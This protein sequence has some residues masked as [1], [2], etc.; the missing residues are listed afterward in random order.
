MLMDFNL[1]L[2]QEQKL[3]MTQQMQLSIKLLQM[4]TYDLREYIE[5][6]FSENPVLEAQYEDTKEVS[7]E[8]D[9]LEYKELVKYLESDNYGSQSYGEYDEEGISPFT[10]I[11]KPESLTDYLEGQILEL[12]IDE[13][14]RSVCSYMVECLDQKGYLDI[15]KEE[16]MNELDCSEETFNRALIVIQ[17]L[18]P[19][20]IGARDLKECLEIQLERKGENYPIVKEIIDNHLDDLADN[21][22]QV[23]AKDLDITPKKAQD[24][25]DLIKTLEPK[26]SRGFYTG[27][28]VGFII[29]D[30]EI[31]KIDGEFFI[32]MKDGVLPMLSVNPLYKDILKDSTNDKE[33]TEYVKEK[34]DKAMF[35]IK[36]IE[37]R[38]STLHKVLQKILEKQKDYFEKGEKYLKPMTLKEIAEKLE[39][40][41]S[42]ISRAIRDKYILTSMGTIKIKDLFVN[43]ISNKEKS[44]GEE[45]V[46]VINIKKVLEEVIK[47][48]DKRKPLS[49]QAI[50]EILKEKGMAISRRT[51][52]KYREE[53]GIKSSS[54]RKR[55]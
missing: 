50:S 6:E 22:Y 15:K 39:M 10:F 45:D 47:E 23:I 19:A 24:Y 11:S 7:K 40:H 4:S 9:R 21:R 36:S 37:Q 54:K 48:E 52:A 32:L 27:D 29:P 35:L 12:P 13:Y 34:I 8:Q 5:K 43:S 3:I 26:P 33:A 1:N 53:L 18:E 14:M 55:F 44:D 51:V 30:A 16:L 25:G 46:T 31:R 2:T 41:E 28:E 17:N 38:K 20:G 49:D 42:T